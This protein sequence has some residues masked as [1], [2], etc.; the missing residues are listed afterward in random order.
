LSSHARAEITAWQ[1]KTSTIDVE[2]TA[3]QHGG[4]T[5]NAKSS[6]GQCAVQSSYARA[7]ITA[8]QLKTSTLDVESSTAQ[9]AV[10]S[11][12]ARA[13]ITAWRLKHQPSTSKSRLGSTERQHST[14]N[15]PQD[16]APYSPPTPVPKLKL[17]HSLFL[18]IYLFFFSFRDAN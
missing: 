14:P 13:E 15:Y 5:L 2:I 11:S 6:T 1:L 8:R 4:S 9:C 7:E 12:H 18:F 16:S 3:R 17:K 10:L